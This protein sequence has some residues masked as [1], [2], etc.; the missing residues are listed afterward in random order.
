LVVSNRPPITQWERVRYYAG[1]EAAVTPV[2]VPPLE[3]PTPPTAHPPRPIEARRGGTLVTFLSG[4]PC[5][6]RGSARC[7]SSRRV[8]P[9][10]V[11][12]GQAQVS[13][14]ASSLAAVPEATRRHCTAVG[15]AGAAT[16]GW[17]GELGETGEGFVV[18]CLGVVEGDAGLIWTFKRR[19]R[20]AGGM[21]RFH[22]DG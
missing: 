5:L 7:Q 18:L 16:V 3:E 14:A 9:G 1:R 12:S 22:Y 10:Q 19:P 4:A 17:D 21:I 6:S 11:R 20:P 13:R 2:V 8:Q 15:T